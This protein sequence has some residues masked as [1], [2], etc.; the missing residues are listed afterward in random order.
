[1]NPVRTAPADK[2]AEG[3]FQHAENQHRSPGRS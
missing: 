2:D 1:M 3:G